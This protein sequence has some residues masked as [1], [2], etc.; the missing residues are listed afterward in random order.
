MHG[1]TVEQ[2]TLN[3]YFLF[4]FISQNKKDVV[5]NEIKKFN[6][7]NWMWITQKMMED[8]IKGEGESLLYAYC[9]SCMCLFFGLR[10]I[11]DIA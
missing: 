6:C 10:P 7:M 3:Y 9:V 4:I 2:K 8:C 11:K 1:T 5:N